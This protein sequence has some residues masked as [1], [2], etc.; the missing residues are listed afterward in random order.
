MVRSDDLRFVLT[1]G[2][3]SVINIGI[4]IFIN[5]LGG[6]IFIFSD[7]RFSI[8]RYADRFIFSIT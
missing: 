7:L 3:I 4:D 5:L 6:L 2:V 1:V 8:R